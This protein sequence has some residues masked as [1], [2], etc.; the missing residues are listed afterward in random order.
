MLLASV[1][2]TSVGHQSGLQGSLP[3]PGLDL[4][5]IHENITNC[6]NI[7]NIA[8]YSLYFQKL[9][10]CNLILMVESCSS[11]AFNPLTCGFVQN[12]F[13]CIT[14]VTIYN[15]NSKSIEATLS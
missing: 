3:H 7:E 4:S 12:I 15:D 1:K 11:F 14:V 5:W 6:T 10:N 8:A 2:S 13:S 9:C